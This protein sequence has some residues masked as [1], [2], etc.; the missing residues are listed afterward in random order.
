LIKVDAD[1][2][3]RQ[4]YYLKTDITVDDGR[5]QQL[6]VINRIEAER[7]CNE[8]EQNVSI[9]L[10]CASVKVQPLQNQGTFH[11]VHSCQ[12]PDGTI[13]II[14][15]CQDSLF[16]Q[17]I[18]FYVDSWVQGHL[19]SVGLPTLGVDILDSTLQA[20]P[21]TWM[22]MDC[23]Q[24]MPMSAFSDDELDQPI[25]MRVL[26]EALHRVH[27]IKAI[28][29]AGPL[30]I[31]NLMITDK[32]CGVRPSW[33]E[34]VFSCLDDH[35]TAAVDAE[36]LTI[37]EKKWVEGLSLLVQF[38]GVDEKSLLHGDPGNPNFF[39]TDKKISAL[40][41]WEDAVVG[42]ALHDVAFWATF[43]PQRRWGS[44]FHGYGA[45]LGQDA[46]SVLRFAFYFLRITLAKVLHRRRFAYCDMIGRP[47]ARQR[48]LDALSLLKK[49]ERD[50]VP[51][52]L[53]HD[54]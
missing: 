17:D 50:G 53:A 3:R 36:Y 27:M 39:M 7:R 10:R 47:T 45:S 14:R 1:L 37:Q 2:Q 8:L 34:Y 25:V 52:W 12:M 22:L 49:A 23:A 40:L 42:D 48:V 28:Y 31:K 51:M 20:L 32:L 43:H 21:Y 15:S 33:K 54:D 18:S 24:G 16:T 4:G 44:F 6:A 30:D 13:K 35:L 11:L 26:G 9:K 19:P 5:L 29:G 38:E 41:D 46:E